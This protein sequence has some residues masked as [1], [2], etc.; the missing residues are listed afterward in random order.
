LSAIDTEFLKSINDQTIPFSF[1]QEVIGIVPI[2]FDTLFRFEAK[3]IQRGRIINDDNV[4]PI[5]LQVGSVQAPVQSIP[6]NS[7]ETFDGWFSKIF[8]TPDTVTGKGFLE[9]DLVSSKD[10]KQR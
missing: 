6:P 3:L 1:H 4:N 2:K 8:I 10:A 7:D 9:L 5:L